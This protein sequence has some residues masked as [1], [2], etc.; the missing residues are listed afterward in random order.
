MTTKVEKSIQVDAPVRAVYNQWTQF[1]EFPQ[2]MGGVQQVTQVD[3]QTV[4][5]V[6]EIGGVK[7]EWDAAILEQVPD[8][9]VAW[10][11]V[12]GRHERRR[13]VLHAG[14]R[15]RHVGDPA[16]GVRARGCRREG[17]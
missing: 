9:K 1:E 6:A 4:H 10:A 13:G 8:R 3:D 16:P 11:A 2:F 17:R 12:G 5:W 15:R 7:R 14:R